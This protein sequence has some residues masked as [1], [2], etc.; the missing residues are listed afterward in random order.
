[1]DCLRIDCGLLPGEAG[2]GLCDR[3]FLETIL[4][5]TMSTGTGLIITFELFFL[6]FERVISFYGLLEGPQLISLEDLIISG[7]FLGDAYTFSL[8]LSNRFLI[9]F[10][11]IIL[12]ISYSCFCLRLIYASISLDFFFFWLLA[13]LEMKE[14]S[15]ELQILPRDWL[16]A[17]E[18]FFLIDS[19]E[20]EWSLL[21]SSCPS[22]S[23]SWF[24]L[25]LPML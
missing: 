2:Y 6:E 7:A 18:S 8:N 25:F 16:R 1:M 11:F 13:L 17:E 20:S 22:L 19:D 21:S 9:P 5:R 14:L 23:S 10:P 24:C 3:S 12:A 15:S 4:L